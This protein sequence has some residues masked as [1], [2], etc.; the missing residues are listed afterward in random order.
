MKEKEYV[1]PVEACKVLGISQTSLFNYRARG[2]PYK[3]K[4]RGLEHRYYYNLED[5][6]KWIASER[7]AIA[8]RRKK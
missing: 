2:C 8:D 7:V 3:E 5:L 1:G 6:K 4:V